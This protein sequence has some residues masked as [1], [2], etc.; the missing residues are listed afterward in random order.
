MARKHMQWRRCFQGPDRRLA[1]K[2]EF[3]KLC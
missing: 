2:F 3:H 1:V